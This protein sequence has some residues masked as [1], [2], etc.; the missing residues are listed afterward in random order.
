MPI[1]RQIYDGYQKN[2]SKTDSTLISSF[3]KKASNKVDREYIKEAKNDQNMVKLNLS[4][5]NLI[6]IETNKKK[7]TYKHIMKI[8]ISIISLI[9]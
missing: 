5:W 4:D 9:N 6:G 8:Y 1:L 2:F 7:Y 3:E